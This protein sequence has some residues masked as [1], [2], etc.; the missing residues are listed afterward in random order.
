MLV[1][2]WS[3]R[4]QSLDFASSATFLVL[5]FLPLPDIRSPHTIRQT[6]VPIIPFLLTSC[7][8]PPGNTEFCRS[9]TCHL[10]HSPNIQAFCIS[11]CTSAMASPILAILR[12]IGSPAS[13]HVSL[14]LSSRME[15]G[16]TSARRV[17]HPFIHQ[18]SPEDPPYRL[19]RGFQL[20]TPA[21]C[22]GDTHVVPFLFFC[23]RAYPRHPSCR[24]NKGRR[25]CRFSGDL[26]ASS[27]SAAMRDN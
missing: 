15:S 9:V 7:W 23:A 14:V 10:S 22:P 4:A 12:K 25:A 13:L 19:P 5:P 21:R 17:K 18:V 27:A 11:M 6:L 24:P 3:L 2:P 16:S 20:P 8:M 1:P 26:R